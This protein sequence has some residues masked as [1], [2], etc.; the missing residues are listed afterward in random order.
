MVSHFGCAFTEYPIRVPNEFC[1]DSK[2][3]FSMN[4]I[5]TLLN[6]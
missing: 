1:S 3:Y 2:S 4:N 5:N 6:I